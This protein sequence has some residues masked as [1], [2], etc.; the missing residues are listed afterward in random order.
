[1]PAWSAYSAWNLGLLSLGVEGTG[2]RLKP[3]SFSVQ[4]E[5]LSVTKTSPA[6]TSAVRRFFSRASCSDRP[7]DPVWRLL[8]I[9]SGGE[10]G[11]VSVSGDVRFHV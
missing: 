10:M 8:M 1:M 2:G 5:R 9:D 4:N 3:R 7:M 11:R 6:S